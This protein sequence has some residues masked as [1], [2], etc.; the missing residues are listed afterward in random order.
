MCLISADLLGLE[1]IRTSFV[2]SELS[3]APHQVSIVFPSVAVRE[4]Q[5]I[6]PAACLCSSLL[7]RAVVCQRLVLLPL[8]LI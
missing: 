8:T 2:P 6:F 5:G 1:Q 7:C 4:S 3:L